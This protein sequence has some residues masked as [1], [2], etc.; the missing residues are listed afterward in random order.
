MP[1][2]L[3]CY[4]RQGKNGQY[5]TCN[6]DIAENKGMKKPIKINTK[7]PKKRIETGT[8]NKGKVI[9]DAPKIKTVKKAVKKPVKK[10]VKKAVA[11]SKGEDIKF[12]WNLEYLGKKGTS[13][14]QLQP[15]L[16]KENQ[17]DIKNSE[18]RLKGINEGKPESKY[19]NKKDLTKKLEEYKKYKGIS[20]QDIK[21]IKQLIEMSPINSVAFSDMR[22][23]LGLITGNIFAYALGKDN[24]PLDIK[25]FRELK[26]FN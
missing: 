20:K 15:I 16:F 13:L 7:Y 2:K 1:K 23:G 19:D 4:T 25:R 14:S 3:K 8:L 10:A 26:S 17:E 24:K 11:K 6:K 12:N 22:K 21:K 9:K 18:R 5:T